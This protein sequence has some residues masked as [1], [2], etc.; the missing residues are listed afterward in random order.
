MGVGAGFSSLTPVWGRGLAVFQCSAAGLNSPESPARE[1]EVVVGRVGQVLDDV[2]GPA[3]T[4]GLDELA[5][6]R[7]SSSDLMTLWRAFCSLLGVLCTAP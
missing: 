6:G 4:S 1:K 7:Y 2:P 5:D 3:L